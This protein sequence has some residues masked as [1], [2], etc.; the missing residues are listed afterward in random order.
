MPK[1]SITKKA[2][3][4]I[5]KL[6]LLYSLLLVSIVASTSFNYFR[7][8]KI[9]DITEKVFL[10]TQSISNSLRS[11]N[12]PLLVKEIQQKTLLQEVAIFSKDC[13][14][15][16][17][18]SLSIPN[19]CKRTQHKFYKINTNINSTPVTIFY[20]INFPLP[21]FL[22]ENIGL[23]T[24]LFFLFFIVTSLILY[25]FIESTFLS[26]INRLK[27]KLLDSSDAPLPI[28]LD[29]I[30]SKLFE[31]RNEIALIEK[32]RTYYNLAKQVVHDIRNPLAYLKMMSK[33]NHYDNYTFS[34]KI[35]E[36][37]YQVNNLLLPCKQIKTDIELDDLF[38]EI[39]NDLSKLFGINVQ[40]CNDLTAKKIQLTVNEFDLKNIFT[41]LARNSFEAGAHS[42]SI[43]TTTTNHFVD[44]TITDDGSGI[45]EENSKKLFIKN[46][47]TKNNGNGIGLHSL[48][49]FVETNGGLFT[50]NSLY[51]TGAQFN[52]TLPLLS[53][54]Q[55]YAV[56]DDDKFI[57]QAWEIAATKRD[58][59]LFTF[60]SINFFL[61]NSHTI[62]KNT[63]IFVDSD[64]GDEKGEL[65]SQKI[66]NIGFKT[67]FLATSFDD[68][69]ISKFPWLT[70]ISSKLPPF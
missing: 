13:I 49:S 19:I 29:F 58:I 60:P 11:E 31:L 26:P 37:D 22:K 56:I 24:V 44:F 69:D 50:H 18:T 68:I 38:N 3:Y 55:T 43:E 36:I 34:K 28:E 46:F 57:R 65:D 30:E 16:A 25:N 10:S 2:Y 53:G 70:G 54:S 8:S 41:N 1:T 40:Y 48:K 47:T 27:S 39:I 66:F 4:K 52:F 33:L 20:K 14:L 51:R 32:D 59:K 63:Q 17:S 67:I 35:E 12:F 61:E 7:I 42:L 23:F 45:S 9:K 15:K 21:L 64:L 5:A 6:S 62:P